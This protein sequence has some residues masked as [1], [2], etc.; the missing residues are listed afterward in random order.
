MTVHGLRRSFAT[1]LI[2]QGVRLEVISILLGHR[3]ITTTHGQYASV[4][5]L[6]VKEAM[7]VWDDVKSAW[8]NSE[9]KELVEDFYMALVDNPGMR[10]RERLRKKMQVLIPLY[11][12]QELD[13]EDYYE[14]E[15]TDMAA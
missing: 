5:D 1:W 10:V 4:Q 12:L 7:E 14:G 2:N 9:V 3:Q 6:T 13:T 11:N 8:N 15:G